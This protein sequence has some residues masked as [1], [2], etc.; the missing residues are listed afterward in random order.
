MTE[1]FKHIELEINSQ[2]DMNCPSCDRFVDQKPTGPMTLAQVEYFV[3]ESLDLAWEWERIHIL[4]GE[5][6]L[7]L[8]LRN[9]VAALVEYRSYYPG[10]VLRVIS[11]GSGKLAKHRE[12]LLEQGVE[13]NVESKDGKTPS[14]FANMLRA[15]RDFVGNAPLAPCSIFGI[16]GCGLGLT[17][18]GIFLCGAG[19]AIARVCGLDIG[20]QSLRDVT[21]ESITAQ[22]AALCNVCGH[23]EVSPS[24]AA[25]DGNAVSPFWQRALAAAPAPLTLYGARR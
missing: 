13:V 2:C 23:H 9:I 17:K 7:H 3:E 4:G 22:A 10:V 6:T 18:H 16:R 5:P 8:Q 19:A 21:W 25:E 1:R 11:N 20:L 15:P 12:W 24:L 14:Y